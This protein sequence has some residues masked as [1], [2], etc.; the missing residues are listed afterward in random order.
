CT[1][2][3]KKADLR[4]QLKVLNKEMDDYKELP[5]IKEDLATCREADGKAREAAAI[6]IARLEKENAELRTQLAQ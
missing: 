1:G 4:E 3:A 6:E 5:K 2:G